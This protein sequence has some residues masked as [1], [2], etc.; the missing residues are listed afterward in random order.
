[1]RASCTPIYLCKGASHTAKPSLFSAR[2]RTW[3]SSSPAVCRVATP[4]LWRNVCTLSEKVAR[5]NS[6]HGGRASSAASSEHLTSSRYSSVP[7]V[8]TSAT[9]SGRTTCCCTSPSGSCTSERFLSVENLGRSAGLNLWPGQLGCT[10]LD[11]SSTG[12]KA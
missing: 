1:M 12:P 5:P 9:H 11:R 2:H 7:V 10:H 8:S 3:P 4:R 6:V